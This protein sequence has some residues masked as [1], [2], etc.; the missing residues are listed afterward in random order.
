MKK[1]S[2]KKQEECSVNYYV[3]F[4]L[5]LC[6]LKLLPWLVA[7]GQ[8]SFYVCVGGLEIDIRPDYLAN[9]YVILDFILLLVITVLSL[10]SLIYKNKFALYIAICFTFVEIILTLG[11]IFSF[12][13]F[14][15]VF[16]LLLAGYKI[17]YTKN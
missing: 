2:V 6:V 8:G 3:L 16:G 15:G 13:Y 12:I 14:L 5:L 10:G 7:V 4:A 9:D 17:L 1:K 11:N